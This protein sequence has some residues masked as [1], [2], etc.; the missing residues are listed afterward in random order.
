MTEGKFGYGQQTP[1]D[2]NSDYNAV[3]FL[4]RQMMAQLATMMPVKVVAVQAGGGALA[5]A[6]TVSAQPLVTMLDG[7]GNAMNHG[8]LASL[9]YFR[10]QGG[11]NAV[12]I[13]PVVGDLGFAVFAMRD[14]SSVVANKGMANPGSL[15][16][17]DMAD[18]I[19]V[20]GILNGT[21]TQY[22]R[23]TA[24]G[25]TLADANGNMIVFG[26][27]GITV[28]GNLILNGNFQLSGSLQAIGGGTYA[29]NIRT[30]G[31]VVAGFGGGDQVGLQ[32]HTHT[33]ASDSHGDTEAPTSAPTAG[34]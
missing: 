1:A 17:H 29:G 28:T 14:I 21:P 20:G 7:N 16:Q 27:T 8:V 12:I 9:A 34:T 2:G 33:Q 4:I 32:S 10:L 23:F 24:T 26:P 15:R 13:D 25:I 19:Y 18:G 30:G 31:N 6:G 22:V 3:T 5:A 11:A